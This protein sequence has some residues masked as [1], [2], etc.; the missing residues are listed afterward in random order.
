MSEIT[1]KNLHEIPTQA[2][3]DKVVSHLLTQNRRSFELGKGCMYRSQ[4]GDKCAIGILISDREYNPYMEHGSVYILLR[5]AK[6]L[7]RLSERKILVL[8]RLQEIHDSTEPAEW[9]FLLRKLALKYNLTFNG[10]QNE[11]NTSV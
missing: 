5:D 8:S 7:K 10:V 3:F 11:T 9:K 4:N 6:V 2:I 1:L